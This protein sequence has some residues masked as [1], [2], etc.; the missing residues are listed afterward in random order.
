[1]AQCEKCFSVSQGIAFRFLLSTI[2]HVALNARTHFQSATRRGPSM[3]GPPTFSL[4]S[5]A[6]LALVPRPLGLAMRW[7]LTGAKRTAVQ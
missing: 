6:T 5:A 4:G 7:L 2:Q 3:L 1:M